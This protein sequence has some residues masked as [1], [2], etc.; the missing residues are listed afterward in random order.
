M[1]PLTE[2]LRATHHWLTGLV[3][4]L[5]GPHELVR[6]LSVWRLY[7]AAAK[8]GDAR[9]AVCFMLVVI[10]ALSGKVCYLWM[11][12][13]SIWYQLMCCYSVAFRSYVIGYF[14]SNCVQWCSCELI[15]LEQ[16]SFYHLSSGFQLALLWHTLW[17]LVVTSVVII[18]FFTVK[19]ERKFVNTS[20]AVLLFWWRKKTGVRN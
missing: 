19:I 16:L 1:W 12:F 6:V 7:S 14:M 9:F 5:P 4:R 15:S 8:D 18:L 17:V 3:G 10:C 13:C 11:L 20:T 2:R